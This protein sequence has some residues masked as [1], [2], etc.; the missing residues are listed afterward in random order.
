[1][2]STL[3]TALVVAVALLLAGCGGS[4]S[5]AASSA[6]GSSSAS[7]SAA[8]T[9]DEQKAIDSLASTFVADSTG[10]FGLTQDQANCVAQ[11]FVSTF[12][13]QG[14][15]DMGVLDASLAPASSSTSPTLTPDQASSAADAMLACVQGPDFVSGLM[16]GSGM[17]QSVIDCVTSALG[18]QGIHDVL[19]AVFESDQT[20]LQNALLPVMTTCAF[21]QGSTS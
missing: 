9:G 5:T 16:S 13:V 14:L 18:D 10:S 2:I 15:I 17:D 19:V 4:G 6:S 3:R 20:K 1:M 21:S 11:G 8:P 7:S 12:G